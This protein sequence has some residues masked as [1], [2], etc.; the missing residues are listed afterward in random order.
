MNT[1]NLKSGVTC[2]T[3]KVASK[4]SK[5]SSNNTR[6]KF[7]KRVDKKIEDSKKSK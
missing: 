7:L 6:F 5:P 4:N 3:N 1:S 2:M